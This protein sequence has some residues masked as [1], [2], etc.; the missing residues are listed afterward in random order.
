MAKFSKEPVTTIGIDLAKNSVH[1]FGVDAQGEAVFSRKLGRRGLSA[2]IAQ[3]P[4]CRIAMAEG[5]NLFW[6]RAKSSA[7]RWDDA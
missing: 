7:G 6:T 5:V 3:Q 1:V 4:R 2:F